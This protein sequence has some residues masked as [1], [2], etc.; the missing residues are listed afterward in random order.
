MTKYAVLAVC[1]LACTAWAIQPP[2]R[3][4]QG[5]PPSQAT[6]DRA[7]AETKADPKERPLD[8][9]ITRAIQD[10]VAA[11]N[12]H[13]PAAVA[14]F[15]TPDGISQDGATGERLVGR[16]AIRKHF[17]SYFKENPEARIA[18]RVDHVRQVKPD[19]AT[20]EGVATVTEPGEDAD[21]NNFSVLLVKEGERW[22][23]ELARETSRPAP[24]TPRE[25]LKSLEWMIGTWV[26]VTPGVEVETHVRWSSGGTFLL[27]QYSVTYEGGEEGHSG[28]QVIGWDPRSHT[29]RSW[30][31]GSD[32]SFGEGSWAQAD[33][34]WRV[35]FTHVQPSGSVV[36]GLQIITKDDSDHATVQ[37]VGREIDG[38]PAPS[39]VPVKTMRKTASPETSPATGNVSTPGQEVPAR[40]KEVPPK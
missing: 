26:D 7:A 24:A 39:T 1:L 9:V 32:G 25:A 4:A 35:R 11:Y 34:E 33:K 14:A 36:S 17:E 2:V 13:D 18:V 29:I 3:S 31:F 23:I 15:W 37:T 28:T 16:E 6:Q 8:S 40:E 38:E 20:I 19:V 10:Y 5:E 12:K 22:F 21:E 30:T 27:R